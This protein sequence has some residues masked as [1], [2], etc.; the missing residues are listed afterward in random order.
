[1][2]PYL[3]AHGYP[4][5]DAIDVRTF[6]PTTATCTVSPAPLLCPPVS[7]APASRSIS[8]S[9]A[10]TSHSRIPIGSSGS[11]T[12]SRTLR[13]THSPCTVTAFATKMQPASAAFGD[14]SG[15]VRNH[16]R[17][18]SRR[19][20]IIGR[21]ARSPESCDPLVR[22]YWRLMTTIPAVVGDVTTIVRRTSQPLRNAS[23]SVGTT[24]ITLVQTRARLLNGDMHMRKKVLSVFEPHTEALRR[25]D[26]QA[27]EIRQ[28][29]PHPRRRASDHQRLPGSHHA[30]GDPDAVDT[31]LDRHIAMFGRAPMSPRRIVSLPQPRIRIAKW[32]RDHQ[33]TR[34]AR[35]ISSLEIG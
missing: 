7:T 25:Q 33:K 35:V 17:S 28:A 19:A 20:L 27:D 15:R 30:T 18:V 22:S 3:M 4:T 26:R 8:R 32:P 5:I 23:L 29:R 9:T 12:W 11:S 13:S 34:G 16:L 21:Q 1:M 24:L 10:G 14:P 31:A 6:V 2:T